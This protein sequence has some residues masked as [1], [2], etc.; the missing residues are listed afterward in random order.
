MLKTC[1]TTKLLSAVD[2][3]LE[4]AAL[5]RAFE[6]GSVLGKIY[7]LHVF[8]SGR[9]AR[10]PRFFYGRVRISREQVWPLG[11]KLELCHGFKL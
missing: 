6:I 1:G 5:N 8:V 9:A 7:A 3:I 11:V 4:L 2:P 10:A